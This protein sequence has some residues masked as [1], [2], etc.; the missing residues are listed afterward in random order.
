LTCAEWFDQWHASFDGAPVTLANYRSVIDTHL[1]PHLGPKRLRNLSPLDVKAMFV[2]LKAT[3]MPSSLG[4]IRNVLASALREAERLDL[5]SRSP[6]DKLRGALPIGPSPEAQPAPKATIDHEIAALPI[7]DP[8]RMALYLVLALGLRRGEICGLKW[9]D[10]GDSTVT[11][12]EQIVPVSNRHITKAPK[13]NSGRE[14]AIGPG[15]VDALQQHR[16][17]LAELMLS[18]GTRLTADHPVCARYDGSPLRPQSL[19]DWCRRHGFKLHAVRH[20]NASTLIA[21]QSLPIV[22]RRLGHSRPDVTLRPTVMYCPL[23]MT[24]R[25]RQSMKPSGKPPD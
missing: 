22:T 4:Q 14:I 8:R 17:A 13:Y 25:Q 1:K 5:I 19:T 9:R 11:I 24:R 2:A 18:L 3:H 10:I 23:R 20:L 7:G 6:L 21:T 15:V 16:R 12:R